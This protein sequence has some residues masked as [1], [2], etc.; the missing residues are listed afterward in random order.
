MR[1]STT[2]ATASFVK[3]DLTEDVREMLETELSR[4]IPEALEDPEGPWK[5]L[6]WLESVQPPMQLNGTLYPSF[7]IKLLL[8]QVHELRSGS[9][10]SRL[11]KAR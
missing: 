2:S 3:D 9:P 6:G 1:A 11:P 5:L 10:S 8:D 4:R 7:T